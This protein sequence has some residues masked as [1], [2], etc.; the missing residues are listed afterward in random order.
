MSADPK[1]LQLVETVRGLV[2]YWDKKQQ[3]HVIN[4]IT[5]R[6]RAFKDDIYNV[7]VS[8]TPGSPFQYSSERVVKTNGKVFYIYFQV[9]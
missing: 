9:D 7:D 3:Q 2:P 6:I 1:Y 4:L 8:L 5:N